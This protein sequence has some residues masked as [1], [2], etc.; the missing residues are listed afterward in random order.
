MSFNTSDF[1]SGAG[2]GA[3]G[4]SALGPW[5]A[6]GGGILGGLGGLF[7]GGGGDEERRKYLQQISG[8]IAPQAGAAYTSNYSDFRNNQQALIGQLEAQARGE[9]PSISREMLN[10]ATD[11]NIR[12][13]NAQLASGRGNQSL[14]AFGAANNIG[15]LGAQAGQDAAMGRIKEQQ[16]ARDALGMQL[17]S[18]RGADE[19]TNRFNA[20]AQNQVRGSDADRRLQLMQL[21]D[22]AR[23]G[24]QSNAPSTGQSI[25]SG[26]A[27]VRAWYDS[28]HGNNKPQPGVA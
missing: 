3:L 24:L 18:A 7:G 14:A 23:L 19:D 8:R 2:G 12:G 27:A 16:A 10:E 11:K 6:V 4:G 22:N 9:G 25:L 5:G 17:Y 28:Q 21:N 13:Q 20:S 1:I 26:G 15:M